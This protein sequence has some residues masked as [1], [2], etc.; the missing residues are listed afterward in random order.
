MSPDPT[1]ARRAYR[2]ERRPF[3]PLWADFVLRRLVL[4]RQ[5]RDTVSGDLL[6]EYRDVIVPERGER[7]ANRWYVVQVAGYIARGHLVWAILFAGAFLA[8]QAYDVF[9]P[10]TEFSVRSAVTTYTAI[11]LLLGGGFWAAWRSGSMLAGPLAGIAITS[12]A[13]VISIAGGG[14]LLAL[15]HDSATLSAIDNSGGVAEMFVL[16]IVAIGL[17]LILGTIGG[18]AG[19]GARQVTRIDI[20]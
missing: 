13:A 18:A 8:R 1:K 9:V 7:R 2:L 4:A 17:G 14:V 12:M 16:P 19:A 15:R 20:S 6:E 3:P 5:D 11:A 10:T